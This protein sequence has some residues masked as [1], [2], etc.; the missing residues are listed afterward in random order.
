MNTLES[1][2]RTAAFQ[3]AAAGKMPAVRKP[4]KE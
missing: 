1:V 3:A 2:L 4:P